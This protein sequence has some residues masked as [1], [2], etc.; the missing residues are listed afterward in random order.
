MG[1][2]RISFDFFENLRI[3]NLMKIAILYIYIYINAKICVRMEKNC[4]TVITIWKIDTDEY[5]NNF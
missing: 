1:L 2:L 3:E 4:I 5:P